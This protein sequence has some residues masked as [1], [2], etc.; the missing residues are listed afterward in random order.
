V[1]EMFLLIGLAVA[2]GLSLWAYRSTNPQI[3]TTLRR[4]LL[5][6]RLTGLTAS[7]LFLAE[8]EVRW[9]E[10]TWEKPK[11]AL[12][13]DESASMGFYGRDD[14]LQDLLEGPL[15]D[16]KKKTIL[17]A[18]AFAQK[19][20]P[21]RWRELSSL[22]PDGPATDIGGALRYIGSLHGGRPDL[23]LLLS[24]GAH[25][26]GEYPIV[27]ARDLGIPIYVL[28]VGVSQKVKNLQIAGVRADP[29]V[30]LG[31]TLR[32]TAVLRAWGMRG[33]R[34]PVELVEGEKVVNRG[35][36]T[37]PGD[38]RE[39]EVVLAVRPA[40]PGPHIYLIRAPSLE[41]EAV[42]EDNRRLIAIS[43]LDRRVRVLLLAGGPSPDL[44][45][46]KKLLH[47][48]RDFRLD[49]FVLK[50]S[51]TYYGGKSPPSDLEEY[52]VVVLLDFP[53]GPLGPLAQA[54]RSFVREGGGLLL[55]GGPR[56]F[57]PSPVDDLLPLKP[58]PKPR[59]YEGPFVPER[60]TS[61]RSHPA[62]MLSED[63]KEGD[64]MWNELP[65]LL[66]WNATGPL[67]GGAIAWAVHPGTGQPVMAFRAYGK[68]KVVAFAC[69]T[70]WR[71]D[72][73]MWGVG[74]TNRAFSRL[75]ENLVR[76]LSKRA[77]GEVQIVPENPVYRSGEPISFS[78]QV[79]GRLS[80][81]VEGATVLLHIAGREVPLTD[82]GRG[83]YGTTLEGLPPGEYPFSVVARK[84]GEEVGRTEGMLLVEPFSMEYVRPEGDEEVLR[85]I[86]ELSGGH[87]FSSEG[88]DS[89]MRYM[90]LEKKEVIRTYEFGVRRGWGILSVVVLPLLME[91]GIRRRKGML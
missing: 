33:Q 84:E 67:K 63:P 75:F 47:G 28:G 23:V 61:G 12:L 1:K 74:S 48:H 52:D 71:W 8:P 15:Q 34:V 5:G 16:L 7:F 31:D 24:D 30:Y 22:S 36:V 85:R 87:Y 43:V 17:K 86:A 55:L 90:D 56:A 41:G 21:I 66:A 9:K 32:V 18:Y 6:L 58:A 27:P 73:M 38:G 25:N 77:R 80:D 57:G 53:P 44:A 91:W 70:F 69:A 45:F 39:R 26:V 4:V 11:L 83:E 82:R 60:T 88:A 59:L 29:I 20:R 50:D 13:V 35:E 72:L 65:P 78:G 51:N 19:C 3:S 89:L 54:L 46:L 10:R 2:W 76:W 40:E 37:L 42:E 49:A 68:G 14:A 62:L 81:P 64:R 79:Y